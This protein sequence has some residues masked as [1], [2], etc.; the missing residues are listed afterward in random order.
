MANTA[1]L[2]EKT[3]TG[4]FAALETDGRLFTGY[5]QADKDNAAAVTLRTTDTPTEEVNLDPGEWYDF[6]G[7]DLR[8]IEAKGNTYKLRIIGTLH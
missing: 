7:I 5:V 1:Y 4:S 6:R 2:R 8:T 3:L